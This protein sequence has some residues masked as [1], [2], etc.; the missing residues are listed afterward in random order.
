M[1]SRQE[2]D[3]AG[4]ILKRIRGLLASLE[5]KVATVESRLDEVT[6][7]SWRAV[8]ALESEDGALVD[9]TSDTGETEA[10]KVELGPTTN[11]DIHFASNGTNAQMT[12]QVSEDG[13]EWHDL[14]TQTQSDAQAIHSYDV[15][16]GYVRA[17]CDQN[18][19]E[20]VISAKGQ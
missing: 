5:S 9:G 14:D 19:Q 3:D 18:L 20:I 1:S 4:T 16:W 17:F 7:A 2:R 6:E 8:E 13:F 10:A 15:P 11:V 12:V